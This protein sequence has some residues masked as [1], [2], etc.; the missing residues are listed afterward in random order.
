MAKE[1]ILIVDDE[2]DILE[3]LR[4]NISKEGYDVISAENGE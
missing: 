4:Y 2:E 1:R 3:L